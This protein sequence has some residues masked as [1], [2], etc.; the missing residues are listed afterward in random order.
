MAMTDFDAQ[1]AELRRWFESPRFSGI[2][3]LHSAREVIEW[4]LTLASW[5]DELGFAE[6]LKRAYRRSSSQV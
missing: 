4:D 6:V 2:R 3:R 1:V 5:G